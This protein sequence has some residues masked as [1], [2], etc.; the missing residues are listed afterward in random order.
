M[1]K[2]KYFD[3]STP[4]LLIAGFT[5]IFFYFMTRWSVPHHDHGDHHD[6]EQ[7]EEGGH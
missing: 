6:M 1:S 4:L 2:E 5:L 3:I 7:V